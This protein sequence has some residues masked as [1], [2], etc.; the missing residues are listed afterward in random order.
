MLAPERGEPILSA[1][2][3]EVTRHCGEKGPALEVVDPTCEDLDSAL[4]RLDTEGLK[5]YV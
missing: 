1:W 5:A 2:R 4:V 3:A